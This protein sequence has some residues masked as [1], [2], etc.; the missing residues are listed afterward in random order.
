MSF[1]HIFYRGFCGHNRDLVSAFCELENFGT[2]QSATFPV[3]SFP[4]QGLQIVHLLLFAFVFHLVL[5]RV[6]FPNPVRSQKSPFA[7]LV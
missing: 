6:Q 1:E 5:I 2:E 4:D 7:R 3:V